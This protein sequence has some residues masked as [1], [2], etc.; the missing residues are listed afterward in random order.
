MAVAVCATVGSLLSGRARD[1][2]EKRKRKKRLWLQLHK[3]ERLVS[4]MEPRGFKGYQRSQSL[5]DRGLTPLTTV[6]AGAATPMTA[7]PLMGQQSDRGQ[8]TSP[9]VLQQ[10]YSSSPN[11]CWPTQYV[12]HQPPVPERRSAFRRR[13]S[14]VSYSPSLVS[15]ILST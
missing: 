1:K 7:P 11:D 2:K 8:P 12:Q 4:V 13:V 3:H 6:V 15:V 5:M 9:S 14:P 10:S